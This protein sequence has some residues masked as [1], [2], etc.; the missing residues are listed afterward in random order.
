MLKSYEGYRRYATS[1]CGDWGSGK[2]KNSIYSEVIELDTKIWLKTFE[3]LS[4][5]TTLY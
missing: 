2:L 5:Y 1:I 3:V 4:R